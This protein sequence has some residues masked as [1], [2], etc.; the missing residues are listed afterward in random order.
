[1]PSTLYYHSAVVNNGYIY[2]TGGWIVAANTSTVQY[3]QINSNGTL[4]AWLT[5][6]PL[7]RAVYGHSAV[8]YN[9]YIY[10]T[11]GLAYGRV[12]ISGTS[13]D[14]IL[15]GSTAFSNADVNAGWTAGAG[16]EG[17]AWNPWWTWKVE[18]LYL[19]LGL[20][21]TAVSSTFTMTHAATKFTDHV[22][23]GGLN[24]HF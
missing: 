9:G 21:D 6:T 18:Y 1:L 17:V 7:P 10:A 24:F 2:T 16:V 8:V 5:T 12:S 22:V 15:G 11:G 4:G 20:L 3:A 14:N 13:T 23:R 19:D